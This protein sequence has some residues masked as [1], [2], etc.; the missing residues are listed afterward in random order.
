M[1]RISAFLLGL[2]ALVPLAVLGVIIPGLLME[3]VGHAQATG[4]IPPGPSWQCSL[5]GVGASLTLCKSGVASGD[6]AYYITDIVANSTTTTG[7]QFILRTGTGTNCGTNTVS[8]F[9]SAASVSRVGYAASTSPATILPFRTPIPVPVGVDLCVL[10]TATQ[11]VTITI[12][13]FMAPPA[14]DR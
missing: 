3:R 9:P 2:L 12:R 8:L 11:T 14:L 10:G 13:G 1:R 4:Y 6:L 5:D 7:G